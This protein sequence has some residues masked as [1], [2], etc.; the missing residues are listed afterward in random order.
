MEELPPAPGDVATDVLAS[1]TEQSL[2]SSVGSL[3]CGYQ[4]VLAELQV[5]GSRDAVY[6][7]HLAHAVA[8]ISGAS[9]DAYIKRLKDVWT[10]L[11]T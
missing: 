10:L 4:E 3:P 5:L 7:L 1:F 9:G 2:V 11:R 8:E 6:A